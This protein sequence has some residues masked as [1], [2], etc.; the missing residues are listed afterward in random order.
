MKKR[1]NQFAKLSPEDRQFVHELCEQYTYAEAVEILERPR[2]EGLSLETNISSLCRF[3]T[4]YHPEA[5]QTGVTAQ[6]CRAV[7]TRHQAEGFA[8]TQAIL[9]LTQNRLIDALRSGKALA[10]LTSEYRLFF[11]SHKAWLAENQWRSNRTEEELKQSWDTFADNVASSGEVDFIWN[12]IKDPVLREMTVKEVEAIY[13]D[14]YDR[15]IERAHKYPD[16]PKKPK[17]TEQLLPLIVEMLRQS[18]Q[19][20]SKDPAA[21]Q[22]LSEPDHQESTTPDSAKLQDVASKKPEIAQIAPNCRSPGTAKT[23]K[24]NIPLL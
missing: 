19:A 14:E 11:Q 22:P 12:D 1:T 2:P 9:A 24:P 3:N 17:I 15:E 16:Q 8:N 10:N 23:A 20:L 6:F 18:G 4:R 7:S 5:R 21:S 13:M